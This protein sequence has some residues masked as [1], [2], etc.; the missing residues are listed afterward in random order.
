MLL[1]FSVVCSITFILGCIHTSAS[2]LRK[3]FRVHEALTHKLRP[4]SFACTKITGELHSMAQPTLKLRESGI[5]FAPLPNALMSPWHIMTLPLLLFAQDRIHPNNSYIV[6]L[7]KFKCPGMMKSY[8]SYPPSVFTGSAELDHSLWFQFASRDCLT[9]SVHP[10]LDC[11][12]IATTFALQVHSTYR[13]C[14]GTFFQLR[15]KI[16]HR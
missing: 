1:F 13:P 4:L 15:S 2:P 5:V 11:V 9:S 7:D 16:I 6:P 3:R 8:V 10:L 14:D 12:D